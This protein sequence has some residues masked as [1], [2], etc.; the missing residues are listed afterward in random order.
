MI[1]EGLIS[2]RDDDG[3]SHWSAIGPDVDESFGRFEL[4]P[5]QTSRTCRNLL[6]SGQGVFHVTDDVESI[7]A[8]VS[9]Q[10]FS[11]ERL[12]RAKQIEGVVLASACR[13]YELV[14]IYRDAS[15]PRAILSCSVLQTH[16]FR[17]FFGFNRAKHA[18]IEAAILA[19]RAQFLPQMEIEAKWNWLRP[20]VE[21]T[22]GDAELRAF[23]QLTEFVRR[24]AQPHTI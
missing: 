11:P 12:V 14:V 3:R 10:D 18:V 24:A 23:D 7:A 2:T 15:A 16:R 17:D 13:A 22:G 4:R 1:V 21:K 20:I 5:F 9:G 8:A 6:R 19:T